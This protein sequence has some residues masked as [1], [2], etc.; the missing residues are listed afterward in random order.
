MTVFILVLKVMRVDL[1]F[2][3][4]SKLDEEEYLQAQ[5]EISHR[6]SILVPVD[7]SGRKYSMR[8]VR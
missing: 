7:S 4:V 1:S 6:M 8:S 3:L 5:V 2:L